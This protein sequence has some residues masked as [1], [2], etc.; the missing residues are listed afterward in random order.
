M[1]S[2]EDSSL[3]LFFS[4]A[5][6]AAFFQR[7]ASFSGNTTFKGNSAEVNGGEEKASKTCR[8]VLCLPVREISEKIVIGLQK[9]MQK[10]RV[11]GS[12]IR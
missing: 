6:G 2:N 8:N 11:S 3:A 10:A 5:G 7:N 12:T 1:T 9:N 4:S